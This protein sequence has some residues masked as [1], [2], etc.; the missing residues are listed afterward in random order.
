MKIQ[1]KGW[2]IKN[3]S[4]KMNDKVTRIS[5]KNS[6]NLSIGHSFPEDSINEFGIGFIIN[7][8]DVEFRVTLEM[9][10]FFQVD[11]VIDEQFKQ[12]DFI[13]VNAPAIAFPYVR[14]YISNLTLQ[15]GFDPIILPSVNFVKLNESKREE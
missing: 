5:K 3:L 4:F 8:K 15:S 9:L 6:F 14:S 13:N 2:K 7:I 10:F 12:S 1:L 11:Q